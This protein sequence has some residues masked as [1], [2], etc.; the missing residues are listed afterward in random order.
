MEKKSKEEEKE[1]EGTP[2]TSNMEKCQAAIQT[3]RE[4]RG[5]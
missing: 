1:V 5:R 3:A 2:K 4:T